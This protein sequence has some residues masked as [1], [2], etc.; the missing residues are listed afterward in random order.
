MHRNTLY[1][2]RPA[3][4]PSD[5]LQEIL[6]LFLDIYVRQNLNLLANSATNE[7]AK[8]SIIK[9]I[10]L[11]ITDNPAMFATKLAKYKLPEKSKNILIHHN[12]I[13]RGEL[14]LSDPVF[15]KIQ[16]ALRANNQVTAAQ[17]INKIS[18]ATVEYTNKF[19][20]EYDQSVTI[21]PTDRLRLSPNTGR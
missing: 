1:S 9:L 21:F 19:I 3:S 18:V 12:V 2:Q 4:V 13:I 6:E 15:S 14:D 10:K 11:T 5:P 16:L 7:S 20:A 17:L 8:N